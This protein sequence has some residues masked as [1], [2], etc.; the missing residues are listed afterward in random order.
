MTVTMYDSTDP[1]AIPSTAAL[2]AAYVD[3]YGGYSEAVSR[4]GAS[5]VVSISVGDNNADV[6]DVESGAMTTGEL[7]AWKAKQVARGIA[8]PVVYCNQSTWPS[9]KSAVS[10]VSWW[11]ANPGGSG[12]ISG[13]DAVQNVWNNS[14][15]SSVVQPS[16]PFYPGGPSPV[17]PPVTPPTPVSE[18]P[19][20]AGSPAADVEQ[21]QTR[22]N[23]WATPI[24]LKAKLTVD[25]VY[26]ALTEAAV[27]LALTYFDYSA[28]NVALGEV[29]ETLFTHLAAKPPVTPVTPPADWTYP[30]PGSPKATASMATYVLSWTAP[31]VSGEA[32]PAEYA[33]FIYKGTVCDEK[34]I[35]L[36]YPQITTAKSLT[37]KSLPAGVYTAHIVAGAAGG[38]HEGADVFATVEFTIGAAVTPPKA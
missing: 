11:I 4:F 22:L 3:G 29:P 7:Q 32:A 28:A 13:A 19:I 14:W 2:V 1:S 25:G 35:V 20:K 12:T 9:A 5:K 16:F 34:N 31:V 10:G 27:K 26:G 6:A 30:A 33:V 17:T 38:T 36:G 24:K 37:T 15:D 8:K 21:V 18:F 23:S